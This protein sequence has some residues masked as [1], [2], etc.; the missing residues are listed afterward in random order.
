MDNGRLAINDTGIDTLVRELD[1]K[2]GII[3]E[4]IAQIQ[5]IYSNLDNYCIGAKTVSDDFINNLTKARETIEYNIASY[6]TDLRTL[7]ERMH[8]NDRYLANLFDQA[9][10]EQKA[11]NDTLDTKDLIGDNKKGKGI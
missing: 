4:K 2:S 6:A 3:D 9:A 1:I 10:I 11:K 7:Q 5:N 8:E